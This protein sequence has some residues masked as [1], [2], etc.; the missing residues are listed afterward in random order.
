VRLPRSSSGV[1]TPRLVASDLDGTLLRSD[2]TV[3]PYTREMLDRVRAQGIVVAPATARQV[4]GTVAIAQAAGFD[5]VVVSNGAL[6]INLATGEIASEI[7]LLPEVQRAVVERLSAALPGVEFVTVTTGGLFRTTPGYPALATFTDHNRDP[8]TMQRVA[9]DEL[10]DRPALKL[11]A[12]LPGTSPQE[13][14]ARLVGLT[15]VEAT[16]SGAPVV[17]ISA[18]GATKAGGVAALAVHLGVDLSEVIAY[19]DA[20]NDIPMLRAVGHGV[21]MPG[22]TADVIEVAAEMAP[23]GNDDDGVVRHLAELLGLEDHFQ[24]IEQTA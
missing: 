4:H 8:A 7:T 19:G 16:W 1:Q 15:Q 10:T 18:A 23:Y 6:V 14:A 13:L 11:M 21:A 2:R 9:L 12:R 22:A 5:W 17:E 3:S 20:A 24:A